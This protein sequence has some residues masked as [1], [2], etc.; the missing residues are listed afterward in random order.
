MAVNFLLTEARD[1]PPG[2][3]LGRCWVGWKATETDDQLWEVNRGLW[4]L[5]SRVDGERIATLS[6]DGRVQ[7]VADING[8]TRHDVEGV[9][10]WALTGRVLRPGDPVHNA[11]KG[12]PAPRH[13]NPVN[14]FDTAALESMPA[15]EAPG[16]I[17]AMWSR[18]W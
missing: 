15:A 4:S 10:K 11:L 14:Y 3:P 5:G 12:A 1:V 18:W 16:S 8:R 9:T 2:D 17:G 7:V 13:R 6:F